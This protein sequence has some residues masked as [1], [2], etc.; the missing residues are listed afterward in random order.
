VK[1][2]SALV[3]FTILFLCLLG[4]NSYGQK[5]RMPDVTPKPTAWEYKVVQVDSEEKFN[6]LGAQGWELVAFEGIEQGSYFR[7]CVFKRAK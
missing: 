4:W 2:K 6:T 7:N 5:T 1:N 3:A